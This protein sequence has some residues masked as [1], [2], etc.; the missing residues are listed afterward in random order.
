MFAVAMALLVLGT[1]HVMN[2]APSFVV[3]VDFFLAGANAAFSVP[4]K[5]ADA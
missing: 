2:G 4:L 1:V 3:A 5:K